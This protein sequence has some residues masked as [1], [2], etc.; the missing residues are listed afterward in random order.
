[1]VLNIKNKLAKRVKILLTYRPLPSPNLRDKTIPV[2]K[3]QVDG[4]LFIGILCVLEAC[5]QNFAFTVA[6][7]TGNGTELIAA[8]TPLIVHFKL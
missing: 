5:L 4:A 1:M 7:K 2:V 8:R 3:L 6:S